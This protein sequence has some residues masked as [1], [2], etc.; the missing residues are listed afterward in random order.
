MFSSYI[1]FDIFGVFDIFDIFDILTDRSNNI[2]LIYS[3]HIEKTLVIGWAI[4]L[5]LLFLQPELKVV[6]YF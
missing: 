5:L 2:T 6:L 1:L 3:I 4:S